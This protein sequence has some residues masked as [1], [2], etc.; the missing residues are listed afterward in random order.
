MMVVFEF[1]NKTNID[2]LLA[3]VKLKTFKFATLYVQASLSVLN[4][5]CLA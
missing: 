2:N 5:S 3:S 4:V 1:R